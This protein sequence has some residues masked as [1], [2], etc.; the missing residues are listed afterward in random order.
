MKSIT[1]LILETFRLNGALLEAGDGLVADLDLSSARWQVLGVIA[2][3]STSLPV[4]HIARNMGLSRQAVQRVVNELTDQTWLRFEQN[5]HHQRAKLVVLTPKGKS[6]YE[7]AMERQRP[8]A[9]ALANGLA[10][11]DILATLKIL[12]LLRTK[13]ESQNISQKVEKINVEEFA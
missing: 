1:N 7:A 10:E 3:S 2:M 6:I 11:Q 13:L 12:K 9:A 5:P 8:W 4:S